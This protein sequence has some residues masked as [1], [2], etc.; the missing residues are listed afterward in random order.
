M[1]ENS[2][3]FLPCGPCLRH[4]KEF[5]CMI[6][7][8]T[9]EK[10]QALLERMVAC[11]LKEADFDEKFV[12]SGGPG[13]QKVNRTATCTV[14]VHRPTGIS[15]KMQRARSQ[16]LNRYYARKR[17]CELMEERLLGGESEIARTK[18]KIRKQ[19]ER[20]KRRGKKTGPPEHV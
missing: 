19:K 9:P 11:G 14:L 1:T 6:F 7:S 17:L 10:E 12:R 15:V 18:E 13:G 3:R 20:R 5:N 2:I 8:V 4:I 16:S